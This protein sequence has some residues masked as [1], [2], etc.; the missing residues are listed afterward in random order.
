VLAR[1]STSPPPPTAAVPSPQPSVKMGGPCRDGSNCHLR[2]GEQT[3][4]T[5]TR[6]FECNSPPMNR[7]PARS[8]CGN[9]EPSALQ[10]LVRQFPHRIKAGG[11]PQI[12]EEGRHIW[13]SSGNPGRVTTGAGSART[14][15]PG[16]HPSR[17][18]MCR[19]LLIKRPIHWFD[20]WNDE[21]R[22]T[23]WSYAT[24]WP[25]FLPPPRR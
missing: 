25:E 12:A 15:S 20:P 13:K 10:R 18:P 22:P 7:I 6:T 5:R 8:C 2:C 4:A 9:A 16:S 19:R 17:S 23:Y 11:S 1:S 14:R 24:Y 21:G 3:P